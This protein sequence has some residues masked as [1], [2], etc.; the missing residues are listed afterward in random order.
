MI[1]LGM[2]AGGTKTECVGLSLVDGRVHSVVGKGSNWQGVGREAAEEV[3]R[4][5][6]AELLERLG[7][8][9]GDVVA[10]GLGIAGFDRPKDE[11]MIKEG[12]DRVLPGVPR[13]LDNDTYLILRAGSEDGVGVA[14]VSGTGA[15]AVG[16]GRDGTRFRVGGL[17]SDFGD[18]GSASDIG[19]M[20]L[21]A[22]M[23]SLDG[24]GPKTLLSELITER[25]GL[26]RLDDV[27][28]FFVA[29]G[30]REEFHPGMLAP[31]VFEAAGLGDQVCV[32][33]LRWAGR[34]LAVSARAVARRLFAREE[35][36][37]LVLGGSVLQ[38][39]STSHV[40]GALMEEMGLEFP[41]F[42]G[43]V[44]QERPVA[45]ALFYALDRYIAN[46]GKDPDR[47]R[48]LCAAAFPRPVRWLRP[49]GA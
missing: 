26:E 22:A 29:D 43:C 10:A 19:V 5:V 46:G 23:R 39:G 12:F 41:N 47:A 14:V 45:G 7:A 27:A 33:V 44:L 18:L 31:F 16:C 40:V 38:K 4:E 48:S 28:D 32:E 24:R 30:K 13:E 15:N 11:A 20:G 6:I 17:G 36:F 37:P 34:E 8:S 21:R 2:D 25:L 42:R 1:L 3:W 9:V 35:C 49:D